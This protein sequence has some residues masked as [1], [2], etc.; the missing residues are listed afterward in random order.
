VPEAARVL[1][2]LRELELADE[3]LAG[4]LAEFD[5]SAREADLLRLRALGVIGLRERLPRLREEGLA[6]LEASAAEVGT[7]RAELAEAERAVE[8]ASEATEQ[9]A[10]RFLVRARDRLTAV[11]RRQAEAEGDV[12]KLE[13]QADEAEQDAASLEERARSLARSLR[14]RAR[15]ADAA[16]VAPDG[17]LPAIV[18]WCEGA[19]AALFVA[20]GQLAAEREALIR[21]A[22]ELATAA[23][24]EPFGAA[25]AAAVL[26]RVEGAIS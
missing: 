1:E 15:L 11:E 20:R 14:G 4:V 17:G 16:G 8:T 6:R 5:G 2:T 19:R 3:E 12:L 22:N 10:K 7:A 18:Q 25:S 13:R 24:G 9:E 26:R 21:Q 23:L